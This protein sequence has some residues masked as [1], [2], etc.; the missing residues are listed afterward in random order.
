MVSSLASMILGRNVLNTACIG[1]HDETKQLSVACETKTSLTF[2]ES[3]AP[4]HP[5]HFYLM[6]DEAGVL[7]FVVVFG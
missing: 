5:W 4:S 2:R 6:I 7:L 3:S 1:N